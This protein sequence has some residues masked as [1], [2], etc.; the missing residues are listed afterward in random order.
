MQHEGPPLELLLRRLAETPSDFLGTPVFDGKG[1]VNVAALIVDVLAS[2][3][4]AIAPAD[5]AQLNRPAGN[6]K[7]RQNWLTLAAVTCW[8]LH[9]TPLA[10]KRLSHQALRTLFFETSL[11]LAE[12][13]RAEQYLYEDDRREELARTVLRDTG[14]RPRGESIAQAQD[15]LH[16]L[17]SVERRR[18]VEAARAAEKR[19]REIREALERKAAEEA[20]DKYTRE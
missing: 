5:L 14:L 17:S 2:H 20:A 12:E 8:L 18:L 16:A 1:D 9:E 11:A 13:A 7:L 3:G 4:H 15:R 10:T 6:A 19:A